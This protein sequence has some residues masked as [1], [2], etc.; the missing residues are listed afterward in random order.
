MVVKGW[1]VAGSKPPDDVTRD[2][3]T[4]VFAGHVG[5]LEMDVFKLNIPP[6]LKEREMRKG[7][8]LCQDV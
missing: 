1:T 4:I 8:R 5:Y 2:G 7:A 6:L 3:K